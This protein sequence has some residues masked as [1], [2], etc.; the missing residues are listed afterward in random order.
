MSLISLLVLLV[1]QASPD[2]GVRASPGAEG[3]PAERRVST[4]PKQGPGSLVRRC[5]ERC[6]GGR[7]CVEL[8]VHCMKA[9]CPP[10]RQCLK[11]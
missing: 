6:D 5:E 11:P 2:A 1:S 9:P 3:E 7:V 10:I 4:L 8:E